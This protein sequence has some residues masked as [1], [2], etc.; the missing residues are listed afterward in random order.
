ME[1]MDIAA[2]AIPYNPEPTLSGLPRF[3][4]AKNAVPIA[5][6]MATT[7]AAVA[8][9]KVLPELVGKLNG[10]ALRV[11]T[12]TV[13]IV[14]LV[15]NTTKG[16]SVESINAAFKAASESGALKG[17]LGYS[18]EPLVSMDLKGDPHSSIVDAPLTAVMDGNM[19]K[20]VSWYDNEAGY[21]YKLVD[22][23]QHIHS[24]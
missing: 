14:D 2:M 22:L 24:L 6:Q 20:V 18:E 16:V 21:S 5:R 19:V 10:M 8:V 23:A 11:P 7:G 12:P 13:S 9:T 3:P 4:V 15:V 1:S 17:I